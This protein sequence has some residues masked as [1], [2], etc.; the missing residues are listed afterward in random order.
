MS[1]ELKCS[2]QKRK[3]GLWMYTLLG[4]PIRDDPAFT[5]DPVNMS[6]SIMRWLQKIGIESWEL[7]PQK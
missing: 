3:D 4:E 6:N 2:V 1:F 7:P 5:G